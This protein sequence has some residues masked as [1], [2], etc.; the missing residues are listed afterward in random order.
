MH[1]GEVEGGGTAALDA[2]A[3]GTPVR[4]WFLK[5]ERNASMSTASEAEEEPEEEAEA[6]A[7]EKARCR[8][9]GGERDEDDHDG[10]GANATIRRRRPSKDRDEAE[11]SSRRHAP[12]RTDPRR[13]GSATPA[14]TSATTMKEPTHKERF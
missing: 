11:D 7:E 3:G 13:P 5:R 14:V 12:P 6:E 9:A 2:G 1:A 10:L 4:S 8:D